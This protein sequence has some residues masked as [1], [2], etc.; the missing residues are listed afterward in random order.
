M[1]SVPFTAVSVSAASD[2]FE[3]TAGSAHV[4]ILHSVYLAQSS[5]V[6]DANAESLN[7]TV[8]KGRTAGS[9]GTAITPAPLETGLPTADASA[10]RTVTTQG[11]GG[12]VVHADVW[13][14]QIGWMYRPT[15]EERIVI[16]PSEVLVVTN[17]APADA[18]T[19]SG[20]LVFEEIG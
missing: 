16:G 6:G 10:D 2:I 7:I 1:Y 5:D 13:N 19:V 9:G 11:T 18:I 14:T 17:S 3:L 20:T 15:P 8:I 12:T 4:C